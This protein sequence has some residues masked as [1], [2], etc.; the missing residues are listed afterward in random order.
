M[1]AVSR[2]VIALTVTFALGAAAE[3]VPGQKAPDFTVKDTSG[4]THSLA[5]FKGKYVVL[6]WTNP[7][8]PFVK[9]WYSGGAMQALQRELTAEGVVWISVN[10]AAPGKQGHMTAAEWDRRAAEEKSAATARVIDESGELGR[11][12]GAKTTP[13]M[14][15]IGPD[16]NVIY[17]GAIDSKASA[18]PS[19]I[20]GAT[21]YV[22]QAIA[23]A[24]AGKAVS[25]P[26]T[27]PYGCSVKY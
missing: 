4:K 20:A 5:D 23:E 21:N 24:K 13:H 10:S 15:V 11:A 9:K 14:F 25:V 3:A 17:A 26:Q 27:K 6:E 1:K 12:Y 19:D 18:D 16:G 8:C 22:K 7:Q 2:G